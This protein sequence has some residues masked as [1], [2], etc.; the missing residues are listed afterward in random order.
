M[1]SI[2]LILFLSFIMTIVQI[3]IFKSF[4]HMLRKFLSSMILLGVLTNF[5]L[6]GIILVFTAAGFMAGISN[7]AGSVVFGVYLWYYKKR[8]QIGQ[9]QLEWF[10][11]HCQMKYWL[12]GKRTWEFNMP[13]IKKPHLWIPEG[14]PEEHW[15]F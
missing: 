1:F 4:P 8:R 5:F 3:A 10:P 2:P 15:L 14:K 13:C 7:L 9:L 11:I 12:F 6:S